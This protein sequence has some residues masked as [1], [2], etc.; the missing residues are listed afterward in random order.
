MVAGEV[1]GDEGD[2]RDPGRI[3][4]VEHAPT[5]PPAMHDPGGTKCAEVL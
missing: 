3:E 4:A 2:Q 1:A 5:D